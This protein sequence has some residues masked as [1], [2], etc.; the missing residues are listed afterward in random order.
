MKYLYN[1]FIISNIK[2]RNNCSIGL[3]IWSPVKYTILFLSGYNIDGVIAV[4][5]DS[6]IRHL[7]DLLKRVNAK[8]IEKTKKV[9]SYSV[10]ILWISISHS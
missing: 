10:L 9:R 4:M 8:D 3:D 7:S 6:H 1:P 5:N 2:W